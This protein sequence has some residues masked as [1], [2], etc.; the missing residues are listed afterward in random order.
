M[1]V[2]QSCPT[3]WDPMD[4][5]VH[6][7]LQARILEWV[8]FPFSR[9]F[10]QPG[11]Q[12]QVSCIAGRFFTSWTIKTCFIAEDITENNSCYIF[13]NSCSSLQGL[14]QNIEFSYY[15]QFFLWVWQWMQVSMM[16]VTQEFYTLTLAH[17]WPLAIWKFHLNYFTSLFDWMS[18]ADKWVLIPCLLYL[19]FFIFWIGLLPCN[20]SS[21][22]GNFVIDTKYKSCSY[23]VFSAA[24]NI[25]FLL[26]PMWSCEMIT[27]FGFIWFSW[28]L[29]KQNMISPHTFAF[30]F[31]I[32]LI[33]VSCN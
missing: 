29:M 4:Y 8:A 19:S 6:G 1:K 14:N 10:S 12:T 17:D 23:C 30:N 2:V 15:L 32:T 11:D 31:S 3:L 13:K 5:T 21:L 28:I 27:H 25:L 24:P 18:A 26:W 20:F 7:I 9:G 22:I 16:Y 33:Y